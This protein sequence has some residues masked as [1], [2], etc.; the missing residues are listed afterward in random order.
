MSDL[1]RAQRILVICTRQIGDVLLTTPLLAQ[2]RRRWPTATIDFLGFA[3]SLD[4]LRGH[5][6]VDEL[7]EAVPGAGWRGSWPLIRRL[8]R[9]YDLAIVCEVSDRAHLLGWIAARARIGQ[10]SWDPRVNWWKRRLSRHAAVLRWEDHAVLERLKV[11]APFA[12]PPER[13][14]VLAPRGDALPQDVAA[15]LQPR[16]VVV[17]A[18]SLVRYKQWPLEHYAAVVRALVDR[19]VQVLLTGS[20][21]TNDRAVTGALATIATPPAVIDLAGRLSLGQVATLLRGAAL[22]VGP[23]TSVTHIA[24]ACGTPVVT[25]FGPT[26]PSLWGPWPQGAPPVT[27]YRPQGALQ[28]AGRIVVLQGTQP[29]VPCRRAGCDGHNDSRSEC[30][31]TL[32]PQQVLQEVERVLDEGPDEKA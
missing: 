2:A 27:P 18:A 16:H 20:G 22:Y 1:G 10:V 19:G 12:A 5:P 11:L 30:L 31:D 13:V 15:A 17:Q 4:V 8:W 21:S 25:V 26:D 32:A 28:R 14:D 23:D 24:A 7:I 6:D 3:G 9:R 29:C